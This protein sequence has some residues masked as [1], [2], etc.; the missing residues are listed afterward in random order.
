MSYRD[1]EQ[2]R[3]LIRHQFG[4]MSWADRIPAD[5]EACRS[6]FIEGASVF[7]TSTPSERQTADDFLK[8]MRELAAS[9]VRQF[10]KR[11]LGINVFTFGNIA[12]ATVGSKTVENGIAAS[13]AVEMALLVKRQGRWQIA[14]QAREDERPDLPL[15]QFLE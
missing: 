10:N 11:A 1:D 4:S 7:S 12:I 15:P 8:H 14:A 3:A 2:I 5:W 9:K 13:R 6:D